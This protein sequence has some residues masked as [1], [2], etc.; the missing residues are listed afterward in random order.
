MAV[1]L[2]S[3]LCHERQDSTFECDVVKADV[4]GLV[5]GVEYLAVLKVTHG[6][7]IIFADEWVLEDAVFQAPTIPRLYFTPKAVRI[8]IFDGPRGTLLS[9]LIRPVDVHENP[10][11]TSD[12]ASRLPQPPHGSQPSA[13]K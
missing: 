1:I 11:R 8:S 12:E 4:I 10:R 13:P 6:E 2:R 7:S 5:P 9:T 3:L